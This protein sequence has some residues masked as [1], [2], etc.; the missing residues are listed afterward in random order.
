MGRR[1]TPSTPR[2]TPRVGALLAMGGAGE[3]RLAEINRGLDLAK[4]LDQPVTRFAGRRFFDIRPG[5]TGL[6][7]YALAGCRGVLD[8]ALRHR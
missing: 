1:E 5:Q 8:L 4:F 3:Q 6:L 2:E 7:R